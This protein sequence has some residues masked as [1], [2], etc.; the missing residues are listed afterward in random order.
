[1]ENKGFL[2]DSHIFIW[3]MKK[4]TKIPQKL[5]G[6]LNNPNNRIYLS[7]ASVWEIIIKK[8]K[9]KLKIEYDIEKGILK[10]RF[11]LL[12][13]ELKH[14]LKLE[15]LPEFHKDPFDR[16]LISQSQVENLTFITA[17]PKIWKYKINLLKA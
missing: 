11:Q 14:L 10:S 3:W 16:I 13:I 12:P 1:M 6:Q 5:Y 4:S 17:D 2:I 15:N 8:A 7:I 9:K